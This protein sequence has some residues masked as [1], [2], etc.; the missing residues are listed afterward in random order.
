MD[1]IWRI[2]AFIALQTTGDT[3][4]A[5]N[6]CLHK[7]FT[8]LRAMFGKF[9]ALEDNKLVSSQSHSTAAVHL[10]PLLESYYFENSVGTI[11]IATCLRSGHSLGQCKQTSER[12][13]S[14]IG[15]LVSASASRL[16]VIFLWICLEAS[17]FNKS[18]YLLCDSTANLVFKSNINIY[19]NLPLICCFRSIDNC[20][21]SVH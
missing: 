5:H 19:A 15:L 20:V 16:S 18:N 6:C 3:K 4:R 2:C 7:R 8:R 1:W 13:Q 14:T 9:E 11:C 12:L 10:A 17:L 21:I